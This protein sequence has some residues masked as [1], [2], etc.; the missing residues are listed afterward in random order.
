[1]S[2]TLHADY[3]IVGAGASGMAFADTIVEE[4]SR[5]IIIVDKEHKP[6]GHW[7][8]AYS[9]VTLHQPSSFYGVSSKELS[10][11][12]IDSIGLNAGL[13][14]LASGAE[15]A[16]YYDQLMREVFLPSGRVHYF[17]M[18]EYIGNGK[19][20][21]LLT[22]EVTTISFDTLV[23]STY[24][25]TSVPATHTPAFSID[26]SVNVIPPN[27][28]PLI[29][30]PIQGVTVIG[31]GKTG[32]DTCLWLLQHGVSADAIMW[33][34]PRDAWFIDRKN[35]QPSKSFFFDTIGAQASQLESVAE[36]TS[37][38]DMFLRLEKSGVFLRLDQNVV[39][40]M[41]HGATISK[42]EL[43]EIR[44]I[45]QVVRLGR[46]VSL[47][48]GQI[49]FEKGVLPLPE[50]QVLVDCTA[51][52]ITNLARVPVFAENRITLQTVRA[53]Q[54]TFS[55][56]FIA[57]IDLTYS[58]QDKKNR[59]CTVVRLP[60]H[61]YEWVD[62]TYQNMMNQYFWSKEPGLKKWLHN[63]RLDGFM[64]MVAGVKFYEFRHLGVL[65]RMRKAAKPAIAKLKQYKKA[66]EASGLS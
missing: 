60:N 35:T 65:N 32:I 33:I 11:G 34:M 15:V 17:P 26:E 59:L 31:G 58:D 27:Q 50:N 14:E 66:L 51:S 41:F 5:T 49:T 61:D 36:S 30:T 43:D 55:A 52:A 45:T 37:L 29:T 40:K 21:S 46:V 42:Q 25:K 16:A 13:H 12:A 24:Y 57:H 4:S 47:E 48:K 62:L 53:Y 56:A 19:I 44:R 20:R 1:M 6:G 10:R 7:N 64:R 39:P 23:D 38:E 54:P 2:K 18:S 3:L 63:N 22:S 9:F 28:L 8:H